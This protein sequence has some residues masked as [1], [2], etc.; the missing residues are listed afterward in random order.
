MEIIASQYV[1]ICS[2]VIGKIK[3]IDSVHVE[4]GCCIIRST[5]TKTGFIIDVGFKSTINS[6]TTYNNYNIYFNKHHVESINID[7]FNSISYD[8]WKE[9]LKLFLYEINVYETIL[10][11]FDR[12]VEESTK[13]HNLIYTS[14][15]NEDN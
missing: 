9:K 14:D 7:N 12:I 6:S 5:V 4:H 15:E 3:P 11:E 2:F 13:M 8:M 1:N 10:S